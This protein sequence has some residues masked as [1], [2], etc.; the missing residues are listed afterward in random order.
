[1]KITSE[2]AEYTPRVTD[3]GSYTEL[4]LG[5]DELSGEREAVF[6][7]FTA[8]A[9]EE[10]YFVIPDCFQPRIGS[11]ICRFDAPREEGE[12][13][14]RF[15]LLPIF[16][17]LR[18]E[19]ALLAIVTGMRHDFHIRLTF[20]GGIYTLAA[21]FDF[22]EYPPYEDVVIRLAELTGEDASYSGMARYYRRYQLERGA[23]LPI[24]E[25]EKLYPG[26][27]NAAD[28]FSVRIRHGWKPRPA[29]V[30]HQTPE[31]EPPMGV[32]M[33]FERT[34][35]LMEAFARN[36]MD[37]AELCLVGWNKSGHDGRFPQHFPV[38]EKLG[39]ESG[40]LS[41]IEAGKRLGYPVDLFTN[42]T[43]AYEVA[44]CWSEEYI[45]KQSD[46]AL[47]VGGVTGS[48][49]CYRVCA[50][51]AYERSDLSMLPRVSEMGCRGL[52]YVDVQTI[53]PPQVCH[54][55]NH[56]LNRAQW[57]EWVC[58]IMKLSRDCFGGYSSE[59]G[60][61]CYAGLLDYALYI[62]FGLGRANQFADARVPLWQ[63]VYNG[64]ILSNP[65]AETVNYM[66]K[67][68]RERLLAVEYNARPVAYYY[69]KFCADGH[70]WMGETDLVAPDDEAIE[71]TA[72][73]LARE[74][75]EYRRRSRLQREFMEEHRI[76]NGDLRL[77]SYSGGTSVV[78]NYGDREQRYNG[79]VVPALDYVIID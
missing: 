2:T 23:C 79:T 77:V 76:L 52:H 39:G 33:D 38:E 12:A 14:Y 18:G 51:R 28:C 24:R 48:G 30:R 19:S 45:A 17:A 75:R 29:A 7:L 1:M 15:P 10:G 53:V 6:T 35:R 55:K 63:L 25:R 73:L 27:R 22:S 9:G 20:A 69:S 41:V 57:V 11:F 61:D 58:R 67:G 78:V 70:N 8:A 56:P 47:Q 66:V 74:Y 42:S 49:V 46:G 5:A 59:G 31:N 13:L 37:K 62:T 40:L 36:G 43:G 26:L 65:S 64:I 44:D 72:A 54:D 50:K 60:Y 34:V 68:Q 3:C 21:V 4:R 16:G 71:G 32:A